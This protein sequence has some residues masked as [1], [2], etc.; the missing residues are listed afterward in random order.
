MSVQPLRIGDKAATANFLEDNTE[1]RLYSPQAIIEWGLARATNP[2]LSTNFRP[3]TAV[4]L[5]LVTQTMPN[6]PVVWV[7]TGY[8]T[9]ATYHYAEALRARLNLNLRIYT[10]RV[11][12]ARRA[13]LYGGVPALADPA[14]QAFTTEVKLEPFER[15]FAELQPDLWFTGIREEQNAF[16]K[17]LG[18]VSPG[19]AGT[20]RVAPLFSWTAVDMENYL[21]EHQ[22]PDNDDYVDPTKVHDDRECGLQNLGSG[23]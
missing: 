14:H 12:A 8:N 2:I 13:A 3:R 4:L 23:I 5:H 6:I 18:V 19:A 7:D 16:R 22:L 15:A 9:P 17:S 21:Y 11:T 10:P 20:L 1:L